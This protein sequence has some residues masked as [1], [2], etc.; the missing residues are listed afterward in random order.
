M[1]IVFPS[2]DRDPPPQQGSQCRAAG[3]GGGCVFGALLHLGPGTS[4]LCRT[5]RDHGSGPAG[6]VIDRTHSGPECACYHEWSNLGK[7]RQQ[8]SACWERVQGPGRSWC[9]HGWVARNASRSRHPAIDNPAVG[10]MQQIAAQQQHKEM[11]VQCVGRPRASTAWAWE[12]GRGHCRPLRTHARR[13]RARQRRTSTA[14]RAKDDGLAPRRKQKSWSPVGMRA[15]GNQPSGGGNKRRS[16]VLVV[17][18]G[19]R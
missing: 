19:G 9:S 6:M 7:G 3:M 16:R 5:R 13:A 10:C 12:G 14:R 2:G 1:A 8:K 4:G 18:G 15:I 17:S 11:R